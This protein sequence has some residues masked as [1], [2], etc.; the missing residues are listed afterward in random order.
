[1]R[2]AYTLIRGTL[3]ALGLLFILVT[4]TPLDG[5]WI[6]ALSGPW[7]DP[8]GDITIVPGADLQ[9][10]A[11]VG[12]DTYWRTVYAARI[13]REGGWRRVVVT[14]G[15][16]LAY[17][18]RD[19]LIQYGVPASAILTETAAHSTHDNAIF[20]APLLHALTGRMVLVTSDYHM[21]RAIRVFRKAGLAV[22]PRPVP[23]LLKSISSPLNRWQAFLTLCEE[24]CKIAYYRARGWI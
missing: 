15:G 6:R 9:S 23:D 24:T 20:T 5:W 10:D 2:R 3:A 21:Y 8:R 16:G 4:V 17:G 12:P 18:M 14:G 1:M 11:I 19:F 13:W 7:N 22:E